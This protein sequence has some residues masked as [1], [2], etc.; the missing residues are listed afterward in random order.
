MQNYNIVLGESVFWIRI[1]NHYDF[2]KRK[3]IKDTFHIIKGKVL[4]IKTYENKT[5][6]VMQYLDP[7]DKIEKLEIIDMIDFDKI[8][9]KEK[10]S[11]KKALKKLK[12]G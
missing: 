3:Y 2:N 11:I 12:R 10:I 1:K 5:I 9:F 4:N 7:S 6:V 8:L